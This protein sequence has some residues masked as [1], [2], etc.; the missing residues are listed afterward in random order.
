MKKHIMI[1]VYTGYHLLLAVNQILRLYSDKTK[2]IVEIYIRTGSPRLALPLDF[3]NLPVKVIYYDINISIQR[4]LSDQER[5]AIISLINENPDIFIFF[6]EHSPL[7]VILSSYFAKKGTEVHLYEDGLKPYGNLMFH[8]LGL[9]KEIH[10]L[11]MW[12][13]KN[14]FKVPSWFSPIFSKKYAFLKGISRLY[15]TFPEAYINWNNKHVEKIDFL[16]I[17]KLNFELK[18]LFKWDDGLLP[19]RENIILYMNQ[20]MKD[21]GMVE[22]E[23]LKNLIHQFP[24]NSIYIKLHPNH[25]HDSNKLE[26][27]KSIENIKIIESV[28]PVEL[29]TMNL[30]HSIVISLCS[31]GMF[32]N[33]PDNKYFYVYRLFYYELKRLRRYRLKR[34]PAPHITAI[35]N[36][37]EIN[38]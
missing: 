23:F 6:Q 16:P 24:S 21:D 31:T 12:M 25:F 22:I 13:L 34:V 3:S 8:S 9:L 33:N 26:L 35:N 17:E 20:P 5:D 36:I 28:L 4:D 18:K 15:L 32:L 11:N 2:Y 29:F 7:M 27:Y 19:E 37:S 14:G 1:F 10:E 38:F 30:R